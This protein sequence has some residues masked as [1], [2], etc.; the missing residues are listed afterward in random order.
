M[1]LRIQHGG[2]AAASADTTEHEHLAERAEVLEAIRVAE[3]QLDRGE[4]IDHDEA[5][6]QVS[7]RL[8]GEGRHTRS[9]TGV[10]PVG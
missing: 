9:E 2:G 1:N 5:K 7:A 3:D 10:L 6:R 4:G 8:R